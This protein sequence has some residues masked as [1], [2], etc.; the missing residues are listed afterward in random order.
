MVAADTVENIM[1]IIN[2]ETRRWSWWRSFYIS[3]RYIFPPSVS[4]LGSTLITY[5][6]NTLYH[7]PDLASSAAPSAQARSSWGIH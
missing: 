3:C 4:V 7:S 5:S 2:V 1:V 6:V